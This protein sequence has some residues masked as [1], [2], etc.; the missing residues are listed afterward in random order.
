MV[1]DGFKA[2]Y[3]PGGVE[4]FARTECAGAT[5]PNCGGP[6]RKKAVCS[7]HGKCRRSPVVSS[8]LASAVM[9]VREPKA[10]QLLDSIEVYSRQDRCTLQGL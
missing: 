8:G 9:D 3:V 10:Q 6:A 1:L 2:E 5:V 4:A 7:R